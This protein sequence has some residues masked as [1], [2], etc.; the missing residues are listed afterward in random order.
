MPHAF[1][2]FHKQATLEF[3]SLFK[4]AVEAMS[5]MPELNSQGNRPLQMSFEE[6][7]RALVF[8]HFNERV[9]IKRVRQL[10]IKIQN[11]LRV[12]IV[13]KPPD[14]NFKE[15]NFQKADART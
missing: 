8:F 14:P 2:P 9:S 5:H 3:F 11:E 6:H 1:D 12:G 13:D 10:R 15:Q 4:P 7:L